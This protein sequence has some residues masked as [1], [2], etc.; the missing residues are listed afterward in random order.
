MLGAADLSQ[1]ATEFVE[2]PEDLKVMMVANLLLLGS[3]AG[4]VELYFR[5][6]Y[7]TKF[8]RVIFQVFILIFIL[9]IDFSIETMLMSF[10]EIFRNFES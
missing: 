5:D 1:P 3:E 10:P 4:F 7:M 9:E 2:D 8:F 6:Y